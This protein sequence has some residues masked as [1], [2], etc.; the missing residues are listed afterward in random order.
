MSRVSNL[1]RWIGGIAS[2]SVVALA[3]SACGGGDDG[4][5]GPQGPPGPPAAATPASATSLDMT[6]SSVTIASPPVVEFSV[7]NQD[8]DPVSGLTTSDLRFTIA[9]LMPGT[10]GNPSAWQNYILTTQTATAAGAPG[11][12]DTA[13][14][15]TRENNGTLVDNGDGTYSYSFATDVT[16]VTCPAPCTDA[17]GN[18]LDVSYQANLTHRVAIQ[19]RGALPAVNELYTFRPSDG[20]TSGLVTRDIVKTE[21]CNVCHNELE[22]HD[23]RIDTAYCVT[24][25]NPGSTDPDSGNTV[26]FKVMVHKIHR[27]AGLPSG[28][29]AIYGF[30]G[31][32]HDYSTVEFPQDIRNCANCH[33]GSDPD[34]PQ[35]DN[36]NTQISIEACGSCHDDIDFSKDGSAAGAN[37]PAGH[38]GGIV[39]D[40]SECVTCHA[41][42]RIAGSVEESHALPALAARA[43]YQFNILEICGTAVGANPVCAP[44]AADPVVVKFSVTDPTNGDAPYDINAV[45]GNAQFGVLNVLIAWDTADYN[46]I[47][48]TSWSLVPPQP[49]RPESINALTA[50]VDN[51]DGTYTVTAT[52][53]IPATAT[54]SGAIGI[55]GRPD[56]DFDGDGTFSDRI[57]VTS[58]VAYFRITDSTP[59]PRRQVVDNAKCNA[60]HEQFSLHSGRR[61]GE[62]ALCVMCH[63]PDNTDVVRRP[64]IALTLYGKTE[65]SLAFSNLI[66]GV[67]AGA[68][69][70]YDGSA[71]FGFREK[72]LVTYASSAHDYS[73]LRFPG[74]LQDCETCHLSGTYELDGIWA[75]P[76]Q[77]GLLATTILAAPSATFPPP[78]VEVADPADDINISPTAAACASC[79]DSALAKAHMIVPGGAVFDQTQDVISAVVVETCAVC[80]GPG[81]DT[82]V[83]VVHAE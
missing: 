10:L 1:L 45:T 44:G 32:K 77:N 38:P 63:N 28:E 30:G 23:A 24:C 17:Q 64:E 66:H 54:G 8:G 60:C 37:D 49:A 5:T 57:P 9:K 35:G 31:S 25:H 51:G 14:Q 27:G 79:H 62:V 26:D 81:R 43:A 74:R 52:I 47:D 41:T 82:D 58:A 36:W 83:A 6:I 61:S 70:T 55:E 73:A 4:D 46:N 13:V 71:A 20:A 16:N 3:L 34:T 22:A 11:L 78:D 76:T 21:T 65:E 53:P 19:T 2:V 75:L 56:G 72:G 50:A 69:T 18:A 68:Q 48:G 33:D 42:G 15:A 7:S 40:N 39:S 12:G 80:H 29:Y 59:V 67:H